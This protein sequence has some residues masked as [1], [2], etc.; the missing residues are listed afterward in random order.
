MRGGAIL[1]R[2]ATLW[3]DYYRTHIAPVAGIVRG[4]VWL[5][6]LAQTFL[7]REGARS[8]YG[9]SW[10]RRPQGDQF[11]TPATLHKIILHLLK[12]KA[13]GPDG[14]STAALRIENKNGIENDTMNLLRLRSGS[15]SKVAIG[16]G[17]RE[18]RAEVRIEH[19]MAIRIVVENGTDSHAHTCVRTRGAYAHVE[20]ARAPVHTHTYMIV[21]ADRV[22]LAVS[23]GAIECRVTTSAF[24][25]SHV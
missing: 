4:A 12:K 13:P 24:T 25:C 1:L 3:S 20:R 22:R 6:G 2:I 7:P 5:A 10:T 18:S 16:I 21:A 14:I 15:E 17:A 8:V 19:G 11:I 23:G 9:N